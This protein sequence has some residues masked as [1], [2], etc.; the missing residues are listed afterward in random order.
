MMSYYWPIGLVVLSNIIYHICA[1]ST[2]DR[3]DPLAALTVTYTVAAV[4]SMAFYFSM[5]RGGNLLREYS[6]LNW[7]PFVLGIVIVGLEFGN[8]SMY[9]VG[10][11]INTGYLIQSVVLAVALLVVGFLLYKEAISFTKVLGIIVCII[12]ILILNK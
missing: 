12:G 3:I 1:K 11:N 10:W 6:R 5:H 4:V 7:T 9:K 2:P 8:I